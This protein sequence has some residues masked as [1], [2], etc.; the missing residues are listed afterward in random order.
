MGL[1]MAWSVWISSKSCHCL[2]SHQILTSNK[3][4]SFWRIVSVPPVKFQRPVESMPRRTGAVLAARGGPTPY[5]D[6]LWWFCL[7]FVSS[8]N[9]SWWHGFESSSLFW[10]NNSPIHPGNINW[11]NP[12]LSFLILSNKYRGKKI[13]SRTNVKESLLCCLG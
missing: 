11:L 5:K 1:W 12:C 3:G 13:L 10:F 4:I 9:L 2:H 8:P 7:K 6:P